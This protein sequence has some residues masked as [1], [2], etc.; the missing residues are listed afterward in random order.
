MDIQID[1]KIK[2]CA[3]QPQE[4]LQL[5]C[6]CVHIFP[7]MGLH[8]IEFFL[9]KIAHNFSTFLLQH[10]FW[11]KKAIWKLKL[12]YFYGLFGWQENSTQ[13]VLKVVLF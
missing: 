11:T 2:I 8:E 1:E 10:F 12:I 3:Y 7:N 13:K 5:L 4:E 6:L 9:Y